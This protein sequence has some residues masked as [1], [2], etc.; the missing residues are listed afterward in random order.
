[1]WVEVK[2]GLTWCWCLFLC[3]PS[4]ILPCTAPSTSPPPDC[5]APS[6][7]RA[8]G[9]QTS[10]PAR[11]S[12]R[13]GRGLGRTESAGAEG[14]A[15]SPPPRGKTPSHSHSELDWGWWPAL[16]D[17]A[18]PSCLLSCSHSTT[19]WLSHNSHQVRSAFICNFLWN[20]SLSLWGSTVS[21]VT[22]LILKW[23]FYLKAWHDLLQSFT[24]L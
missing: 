1:M 22:H 24:K 17:P 8:P 12:V 19:V 18:R 13:Q 11:P 15:D 2:Q 4:G 7:L 21:R 14:G 23:D 6:S 20:S 3:R 10:H 16:A 9:R 5:S